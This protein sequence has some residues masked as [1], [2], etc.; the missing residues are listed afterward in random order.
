M[1]KIS[2]SGLKRLFG[3][4]DRLKVCVKCGTRF[5][6]IKGKCPLCGSKLQVLEEDKK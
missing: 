4:D 6:G 1:R 3:R 5:K 2:L